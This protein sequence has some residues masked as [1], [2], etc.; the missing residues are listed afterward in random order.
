MALI[1]NIHKQLSHY[2]LRTDFS[3]H[4]GE[5]TAIVGPSGAGKTTLIRTIAGLEAP[6]SGII[7]LNDTVWTDTE[8]GHCVPTCK[9]KIGL[10]FQEYTLFPHMS[11]RQNITFGAE[12]SNK[13]DS[14]MEIFGIQHLKDQKPA[15]I[16]GG[17]RQ[18]TAFCQALASNPNLLLLDEPFSALDVSTRSFLCGVL[19]DLK[20]ELAIPI[21][22]VTH[23]L[24][25]AD[26]LADTVMAVENGRITPDWLH[27]QHI[28][29]KLN[30][31]ATVPIYS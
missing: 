4:P 2:E 25:E 12:D 15:A 29:R 24:K 23:D 3:C 6:D 7:S 16:S 31:H 1:V 26:Q 5:L 20:K 22:H 19:A 28:S 8:T 13:V 14:L 9:R 18:R 21:L 11:V 10:V 17:E 30:R 27:R